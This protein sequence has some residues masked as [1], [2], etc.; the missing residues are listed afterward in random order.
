MFPFVILLNCMDNATFRMWSHTCAVIIL[1][2]VGKC[3]FT[4]LQ[5]TFWGL[6]FCL[7][8]FLW[9]KNILSCVYYIFTKE[10][11]KVGCLILKQSSKYI[12]NIAVQGHGHERILYFSFI[13]FDLSIRE[14]VSFNKGMLGY[15]NFQRKRWVRVPNQ[16][17]KAR[18][19]P[20]YVWF[21]RK[22][23]GAEQMK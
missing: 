3:V 1:I 16:A 13:P 21:H 18:H 19:M 15:G 20:E 10:T 11:R 8:F 14:Y 22:T 6:H 4:R 23:A 9:R 5:E 17:I 12:I 2:L 7:Q